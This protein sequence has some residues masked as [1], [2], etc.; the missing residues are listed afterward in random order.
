MAVPIP[1]IKDQP[2]YMCVCVCVCARARARACNYTVL[3]PSSS[4]MTLG[5]TQSLTRNDPG[6]KGR[7]VPKAYNLTVIREPTL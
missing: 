2:W 5:F 7:P 6:R 1:Q 3:D 4:T